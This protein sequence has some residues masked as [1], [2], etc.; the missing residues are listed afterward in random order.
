MSSFNA[1]VK[2]RQYVSCIC[3]ANRS[4]ELGEKNGFNVVSCDSCGM[5]YINPQPTSTELQKFY[6]TQYWNQHQINLGLKPI[7]ERIIDAGEKK[8]FTDLLNWLT[9]HVPLD[10]EKRLLEVGCSHAIFCELVAKFG[11]NVVGV[12]M[13][14]QIAQSAQKRTG[15]PIYSGGLAHQE[16]NNSEFDVICM[17]DVIEHFSEPKT[18]LE[19][20]RLY[21]K[22]GGWL[23][24]STPCRDAPAAKYDV[25]KWGENK[26][27]EH[28]F[29]YSFSDLE[30]LL[31]QYGFHVWDARGIYSARMY[32]LAR[33]DLAPT[34]SYRMPPLWPWQL[35]ESLRTVERTVRHF[36]RRKR[37]REA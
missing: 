31:N 27:P 18:E 1:H 24:L 19:R 21:L 9:S 14:E 29:L 5:V 10:A 28:L 6:S 11:T 3:G 12:E 15:L 37:I 4:S 8:Y 20:I 26:P 22:Q 32:I 17:F 13:D 30:K 35:R 25:L 2:Q 16:F 7:N 33:R 34:V 23:Y 36:L